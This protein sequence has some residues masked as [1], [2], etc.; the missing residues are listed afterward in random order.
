MWKTAE[1]REMER[2]LKKGFEQ[3]KRRVIAGECEVQKTVCIAQAAYEAAGAGKRRMRFCGLL[4]SQIRYIGVIAWGG[5]AALFIVLALF[6]RTVSGSLE[7]PEMIFF[8]R[9]MPECL[10]AVGLLSAWSCVP[11]LFRSFRWKM[12]E[13]ETAAY[14]SMVRL[15]LAQ[16]VIVEGGAF[17]IA[18]GVTGI[19]VLASLIRV[20]EAISCI[21]IPFL[22][23]GSCILYFLRK[24]KGELFL[25]KCTAA[26]I[27]IM[28]M[29]VTGRKL[30]AE[31]G[32]EL[33]GNT[34]WLLCAAAAAIW[35][36]QVWKIK[37]EE[38]RWS[39]A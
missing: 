21:G 18:A 26:G 25:R 10:C 27:T 15:R 14:F 3:E 7:E 28:I 38:S 5:Q 8:M 19:V 1:K 16:L 29:F 23:F 39:L 24:G 12:A 6:F 11:F 37:K 30:G 20:R 9:R 33:K 4:R 35:G 32:I 36:Y 2:R 31:L 22:V 13:V 17:L 34:A